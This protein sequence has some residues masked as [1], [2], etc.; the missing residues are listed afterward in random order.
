MSRQSQS[1]PQIEPR[2]TGVQGLFDKCGVRPFLELY[3]RWRAFRSSPRCLILHYVLRRLDRYLLLLSDHYDHR[4]ILFAPLVEAEVV[5][6]C[7]MYTSVC[8][9]TEGA[10]APLTFCASHHCQDASN[11]VG[12]VPPRL[13]CH[14]SMLCSTAG[15]RR[16]F[17]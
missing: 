7:D 6:A 9:G 2:P 15:R 1:F 11:S 4:M 5:R 13:A 8:H 12:H 16:T 3:A 14:S 17:R 10:S